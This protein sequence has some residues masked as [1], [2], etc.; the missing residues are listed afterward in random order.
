[1]TLP[2]IPSGLHYMIF[3]NDSHFVKIHT[4]KPWKNK[5]IRERGFGGWNLNTDNNSFY[6]DL[7]KAYC[8]EFNMFAALNTYKVAFF[9]YISYVVIEDNNDFLEHNRVNSQ[10]KVRIGDIVNLKEISDPDN[11]SFAL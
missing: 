6:L 11:N 5:E 3:C 1:M 2:P 7:Y 10:I 8:E 4:R 9:D